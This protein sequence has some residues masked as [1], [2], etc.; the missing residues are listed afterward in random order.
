M[1]RWSGTRGFEGEAHRADVN[2]SIYLERM[3]IV[4][5]LCFRLK[6]HL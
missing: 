4:N 3:E 2:V 1:T 6:R 5:D